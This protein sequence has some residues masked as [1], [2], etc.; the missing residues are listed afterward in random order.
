MKHKRPLPIFLFPFILTVLQAPPARAQEDLLHSFQ[1]LAERVV[2]GFQTATD[3]I[4]NVRLDLRRRDTFPEADVRMV[5]VLGFD[6]KPKDGPAWYSVRLLFG[7]RDGQWGFLKAFHELPSAQP[8]W[9]EGGPWYGTVV[10]RVL[11]PGP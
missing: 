3:G 4:R 9:T 5:G 11:K 6:L 1:T 2:Q 7:Y 8:S 10:E